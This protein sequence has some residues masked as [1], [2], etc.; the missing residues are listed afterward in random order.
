LT[1][2][3]SSLGRLWLRIWTR[4]AWI[5][6]R[7]RRWL[8]AQVWRVRLW[9]ARRNVRKALKLINRQMER[10]RMPRTARRAFW[11]ELAEDRYQY[12]ENFWRTP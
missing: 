12:L 3:H 9:N 4:S 7:V 2:R 5:L 8:N 11:R 6:S 10:V 1:R